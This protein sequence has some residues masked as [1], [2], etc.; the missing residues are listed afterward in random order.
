VA[1]IAK[2]A[3]ADRHRWWPPGLLRGLAAK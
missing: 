2:L 1:D 3:G